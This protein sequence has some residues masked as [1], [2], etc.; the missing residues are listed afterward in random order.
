MGLP[1]ETRRRMTSGVES[2]A[3]NVN[4]PSWITRNPVVQESPDLNLSEVVLGEIRQ[5][6]PRLGNVNL[7][8]LA[9]GALVAADFEF[10]SLVLI[11]ESRRDWSTSPF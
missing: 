1:S 11:A 3:G 9:R 7:A 8:F 10:G 4:V 2:E 6:F 5:P